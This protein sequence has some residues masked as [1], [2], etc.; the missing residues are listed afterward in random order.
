MIRFFFV[1][2]GRVVFNLQQKGKG[3]E[4]WRFVLKIK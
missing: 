2:E 1:Y 4:E 3:K